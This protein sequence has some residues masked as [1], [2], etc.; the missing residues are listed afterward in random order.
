MHPFHSPQVSWHPHD[1]DLELVTRYVRDGGRRSG[2]VGALACRCD[3]MQCGMRL[4]IGSG[5]VKL[6][7][8]VSGIQ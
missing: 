7:V 6:L 3:S 5:E 8:V 2:W 1:L 4:V